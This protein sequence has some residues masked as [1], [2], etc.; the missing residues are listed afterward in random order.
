MVSQGKIL[1]Q[2]VEIHRLNYTLLEEHQTKRDLEAEHAVTLG[3]A[4][5]QL[6]ALGAQATLQV[7]TIHRML[8]VH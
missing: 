4:A 5:A 3:T 2:Q 1:E 8:T 7:C 6:E